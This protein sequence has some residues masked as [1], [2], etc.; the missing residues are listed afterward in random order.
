MN[1]TAIRNTLVAV[2][3]LVGS[4][5]LYAQTSL[6][7]DSCRILAL[8]NNRQAKEAKMQVEK[9]NAEVKAYRANFFPRVSAQGTYFHS[10]GNFSYNRHINLLEGVNLSQLIELGN[11]TPEQLLMLG[12]LTQLAN[13][14]ISLSIRPENIFM[15]GIQVEQPIYMGGKIYSAYK[16]AQTGR[17]IAQLNIER[18]NSEIILKTDEA[19]WLYVKV[20]ALQETAQAYR[21]AV[22]QVRKDAEN[23]LEA[24]M[25]SKNDL[26]KVQVK[27]GEAELMIRQTENGRRLARM[28]LCML[29]GVRLSEEIVPADTLSDELPVLPEAIPDATIRT[30][31]VMLQKQLD[32]KK[33]QVNLAR[34]EFLPQ[35]GVSGGYTYLDGAKFND[36]KL[37]N[38]GGFSIALSLKIP[39]VHGGEGINRV[40]S[41]K[42]DLYTAAYQMDEM[43]D[44]LQMEIVQAYNAFDEAILSTVIARNEY[45]QT[46]ENLRVISDRHELG[47]ENLSSL[48]EAQALWK[49][50]WS[51]YIEAK[52]TL[53]TAESNY[54]RTVGTQFISPN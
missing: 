46:E 14:D 33:Q 29:L 30:E 36:Y 1:C 34:S 12:Q 53:R 43:T 51:K 42:A 22:L 6:T 39:I 13:F 24:G 31:Y 26:M 25:V 45:R 52:V 20:N 17:Q 49:E 21:D 10:T 16:M 50:A 47:L 3:F 41:A 4:L 32:V 28:N 2:F 15:A 8:T 11:L 35:L 54:K 38:D 37:F 27:Q 18:S 5:S 19:Y 44:K 9:M 23:A 48:L 40:R 7:L